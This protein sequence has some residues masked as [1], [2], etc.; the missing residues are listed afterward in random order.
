M[1]TKLIQKHLLKGTVEFEIGSEDINILTKSP[2]NKTETLTVRL[3]ILNPEPIIN[4]SHL[5]FVSRVNGEPLVSLALGKPNTAE[6]NAFVNTL[7]QKATTEYGA[8]VGMSAV[9]QAEESVSHIDDEP[10]EFRETSTTDIIK[11]KQVNVE[12]LEN[13]IYLI[14]T[15]VNDEDIEPLLTALKVLKQEP[16]N[17]AKLVDVATAFNGLKS[18]G[19]VLT[20]A[21]YVSMML[22]DDPLGF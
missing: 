15:Y 9:T 14:E 19:A 4:K 21:P 10:P 2:L 8:F 20:Y 12:N 6:F 16:D 17:Q 7:K 18:Q 3:S 5:E 11:T 1:S 22:S 13:A